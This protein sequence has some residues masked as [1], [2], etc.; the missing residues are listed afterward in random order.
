[1]LVM[2]PGTKTSRYNRIK[3]KGI[4]KY[5]KNCMYFN[6]NIGFLKARIGDSRKSF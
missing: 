5:F 4:K 1:M 6:S 3:A 2:I